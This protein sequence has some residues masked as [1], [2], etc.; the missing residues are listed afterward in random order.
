MYKKV[1]EIPPHGSNLMKTLSYLKGY[2]GGTAEQCIE[3]LVLSN[4]NYSEVLKILREFSSHIRL[5]KLEKVKGGTN[6]KELRILFN[7]IES[8]IRALG[9]V[10]VKP[11]HYGPLIISLVFERLPDDI[12]LQ[13]SQ[14]L[15][16]NNWEV[17][18]FMN[19]VKEEIAARESCDFVKTQMGSKTQERERENPSDL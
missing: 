7:Q 3:G 15:G 8:N 2:L 10:G 16:K 14:T 18:D 4:E 9:I 5:S 17:E 11:E 6:I 1:C 13:I 12:K 19:T